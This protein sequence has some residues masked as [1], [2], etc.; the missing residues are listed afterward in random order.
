MTPR[1]GPRPPPPALPAPRP[2]RRGRS[3]VPVVDV[4]GVRPLLHDPARVALPPLGHRDRRRRSDRPWKLLEPPAPRHLPAS[5]TGTVPSGA[6]PAPPP[7]FL[8]SAGRSGPDPRLPKPPLRS[9]RAPPSQGGR[10]QR[11]RPR[12]ATR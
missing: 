2:S 6:S 8:R 9:H 10:Q 12:A 3:P 1:A 7:K 4:G 5:G 11:P